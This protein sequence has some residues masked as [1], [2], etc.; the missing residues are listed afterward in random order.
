[1]GWSRFLIER[2]G[3]A[4]ERRRSAFAVAPPLA[5]Q[6]YLDLD[7]GRLGAFGSLI[8]LAW[9]LLGLPYLLLRYVWHYLVDRDTPLR[10]RRAEE[11]AEKLRSQLSARC[12]VAAGPLAR[13]LKSGD[14]AHVPPLLEKALLRTNPLLVVQPRTEQ[15]VRSLV[16]F[17]AGRGLSVFPRGVG[18]SGFGGSV[19]TV[20][21]VVVDFSTMAEVLEVDP[22]RSRVRVQPG[23]RWADLKELLARQGLAPVTTPTSLFSTVGGWVSGGG[24]GLESLRYGHLSQA[25]VS[26]RVVRPDG[27]VETLDGERDPVTGYEGQLGLFTEVTLMVRPLPTRSIARLYYAAGLEQALGFAQ[28][29][30]EAESG[31]THVNVYDR[32]RME[33]ENELLA[34][35]TGRLEGLFEV[36]EAVLAHF[37]DQQVAESWGE[38][39]SASLEIRQADELPARYLWEQR[40]FPL[41]VQRL[42]S[43]LLAAELLLPL[44]KVE[45]FVSQARALAGSLKSSPALEATVHRSA[46]DE[47]C[48][49]MVLFRCDRRRRIDYFLKMV[50]VLLTTRVGVR[51]GGRPYGYGIWNT[52]FSSMCRDREERRRLKEAKDGVDPRR[53]LNPR[54]FLRLQTR[55]F[56]IPGLAFLP[57]VFGVLLAVL[58]H[59][60]PLL[61]V[62][63]SPDPRFVSGGAAGQPAEGDGGGRGLLERSLV[64]CARCGSCVSTCPAYVL[65]GDELVTGR[66]KLQLGGL[67][68]SGEPQ[69]REVHAALQCLKC[70][71]CEEVCQTR[72]PLR[73]CYEE[74]ELRIRR[75]HGRSDE[76]VTAFVELLDANRDL[77]TGGYGLHLPD[78]TPASAPRE[79]PR[80]NREYVSAERG[81]SLEGGEGL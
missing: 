71:L 18:S 61:G 39:V 55:F 2:A 77:I 56:G 81:D 40:Y 34:P 62:F 68:L 17:A 64:R 65:T 4:G 44:P 42:G 67:L 79:V 20:N 29:L 30:A 31:P 9:L 3:R 72:L 28:Q 41:M 59:L 21:G 12:R 73:E 63:S 49:V 8:L 66:T 25:I 46:G 1:M 5:V 76:T 37:D 7:Q 74:I 75:L 60:L 45:Q 14:L 33:E 47:Q 78:W 80:A 26:A 24:L 11:L 13:W 16:G 23:V 10:S 27:S 58:E 6:R 69:G 48:T 22:I 38:K 54:K 70:G 36:S 50:L 32:N 51:L 53:L 43:S 19:P 35:Q 15:D 52:P 57:G